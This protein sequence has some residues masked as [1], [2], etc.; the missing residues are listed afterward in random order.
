MATP[1]W[2]PGTLYLPGA[3]VQPLTAIP[4]IVVALDNPGFDNGTLSGWT[5]TNVGGAAAPGITTQN[6]HG[7][8]YNLAYD[9]GDGTGYQG[10]IE[11]IGENDENPPATEGLI[12]TATIQVRLSQSGL[13]A[14]RVR[15]VWL[16]ALGNIIGAP[17]DGNLIQKPASRSERWVLSTVTSQAPAGTASVKVGFWGVAG[18][19]G[20]VRFDSLTWNYT[21]ASAPAGLI[22]KAVQPA[23][24]VSD[25]VEPVWP[26]VLGVQVIDGGVIWEAVLA[27]R[28]VWQAEPI[29]VSGPVEPAWPSAIGD[30][31]TDNTVSW[32]V[33]SRRVEDENCPNS[34]A[35]AIAA[36]K[37]FATDRD[38]VRFCMTTNCLNWTQEKDAGYLATGLQQANAG[39]MSVIN[40]Y[41]S[42]VVCFNPSV[43][44]NWQADPDPAV[45][46]I[47]DQLSGI[48][49]TWQQAAAPVG[50]DLF[51]LAALGVR[52]VGIAGASTNLQAGDVGMPIDPLVKA[53]IL[54]AI[55][56]GKQPRA[57]FYPSA[58]QYWLAFP[59]YP[60]VGI[61]ETFVYS[62]TN[63]GTKVGAWTRYQFPFT[64]EAFAQL[65]DDLYIKH[66][67]Y[68]SRVDELLATDELTVD[69]VVLQQPFAGRV[70]WAWLDF[71]TPGVT[72]ML[73]G[74]D[75]VGVGQA[76]TISV[77][78]DQRNP[79]LFTT[80]Y[81]IDADTL[82][83]GLIPLPVMAPT[84]SV[85][86]DFEGGEAWS[87]RSVL[88]DFFEMGN[89]P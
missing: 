81:Q 25:N 24:G 83:G 12:I 22:F 21:S 68:I 47:L 65:A 36:S 6:S 55:A 66:G 44:Q 48:G 63:A 79:N 26:N 56:S 10:G 85:R 69:D 88:L 15:I 30:R 53:A 59:D 62:L 71:G 28:V 13:S 61:T 64:I 70:Q 14:G 80:P 41:R 58:G 1:K 16:D 11:L 42:N 39:D 49:S 33:I 8:T 35:V 75:Y 19:A 27:N 17:A 7:G 38:I 20:D 40:Q 72:K 67:R 4:P 73:N 76:P 18:G 77:G 43:F 34:K 45:M 46:V 84:M 23:A 3:L 9:G 87:V 82:V 52:S 57:T 32:E 89:G 51:F 86:L 37:V 31:I 74:F 54:A 29:M 78:F 50:N 60:S 5:F 2:A